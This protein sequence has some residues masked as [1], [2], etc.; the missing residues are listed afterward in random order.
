[1]IPLIKAHSPPG[2]PGQW[3]PFGIS[4]RPGA[5]AVLGLCRSRSRS[6]GRAGSQGEEPRGSQGA[7]STDMAPVKA[8]RIL[9]MFQS[10]KSWG[11]V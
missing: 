3:K 1:M 4:T 6:R 11:R 10:P 7:L 8:T 9:K 5:E 2:H